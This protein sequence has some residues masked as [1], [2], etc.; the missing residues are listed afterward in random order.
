MS[1]AYKSAHRASVT[2]P[3]EKLAYGFKKVPVNAESVKNIPD[4]PEEKLYTFDR[5]VVELKKIPCHKEEEEDIEVEEEEETKPCGLGYLNYNQMGYHP[6]KH[7]DTHFAVKQFESVEE[8]TP[9]NKEKF[10]EVGSCGYKPGKII[11]DNNNDE[12]QAYVVDDD[13]YEYEGVSSWIDY[14]NY[15]PWY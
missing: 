11:D 12:I 14:W 6:Q 10:P 4:I 7:I 2:V 1:L 5:K 9:C 8:E 15:V 13:L 3:E